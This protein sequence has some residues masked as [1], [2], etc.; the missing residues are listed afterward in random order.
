MMATSSRVRTCFFMS[1]H[2]NDCIKQLFDHCQRYTWGVLLRD[3]P[4]RARWYIVTVIAL[5]AITLAVLL[6]RASFSPAAPLVFL[7][8][9]SSLTSAFKVSLPIASGSNT[10]VPYLV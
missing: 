9:L 2:S 1:S 8:L 3:L 5:A 10:S 4:S 7:V 6:P